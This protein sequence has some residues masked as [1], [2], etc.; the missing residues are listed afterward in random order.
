MNG[1]YSNHYL[2][3]LAAWAEKKSKTTGEVAQVLNT[4]GYLVKWRKALGFWLLFT[5]I[6]LQA[7]FL[8][9]QAPQK[10]NY[11]SVIRN[12]SGEL[13]KSANVSIRISILQDS[14]DGG[15][16]YVEKHLVPTNNNGLATLS[17][18]SGT[19]VTGTFSGINWG[20]GPYFLEVET[21]PEGR[22]KLLHQRHKP[23]TERAVCTV[24]PLIGNIRRCSKN[25][26][27][28]NHRRD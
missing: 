13:I 3:R 24:C 7:G 2:A 26:R 1:A 23:D 5:A 22:H 12:A 17:I 11:Q 25:Y 20:N 18:G 8:N 9:A 27:R 6:V 21:D 19:P 15:E 16:V 14:V 28:P 4:N 10:V